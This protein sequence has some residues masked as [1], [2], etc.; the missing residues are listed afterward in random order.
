MSVGT[1]SS[2]AAV[3]VRVP[4]AWCHVSPSAI[5]EVSAAAEELGFDGV[6]VQDHLL[7]ESGV[8]PCGDA[9]G[10]DDRMVL[11]ALSVLNYL[12]G[13]TRRLRLLSGVLVLSY[14]DAIL[15]AKEVATLDVL[16]RGRLVVGVGVGAVGGGQ[17]DA[18]QELSPHARIAQREFE[19]MGVRGGR[20]GLMDEMLESM[21]TLWEQDSATFHGRLIS[22]DGL[23]LFP[24]P[25][26]D[27]H[28]RIWIGGRSDAALRRVA[29]LGDGWFP[30]HASPDRSRPGA[31]ASW[32]S[33][34]KPAGR[35]HG[36]RPSTCLRRS[37]TGT[38]MRAG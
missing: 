1:G 36:T 17:A 14:R 37:A 18:G 13:R 23:D 28:P 7:S 12:A 21:I 4:H 27:P 15:L 5:H 9:H 25:V 22:F 26:Q 11:E 33:P 8:T 3:F 29:R 10:Q 16:S 19:A 24:K 2:A 30:S 35:H 20:G 6:S 32:S 31:G 34:A 38:R